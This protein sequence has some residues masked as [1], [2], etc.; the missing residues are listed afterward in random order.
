MKEHR[1]SFIS[2]AIDA[3]TERWSSGLSQDEHHIIQALYASSQAYVWENEQSLERIWTRVVQRR[4]YPALLQETQHE[5][6]EDE[7]LVSKGKAIREHISRGTRFLPSHSWPATCP[8]TLR[9]VLGIGTAVAVV[10]LIIVSWVLLFSGLRQSTAHH[11]P[12]TQAGALQQDVHAG[13]LVCSFSANA[14][15]YPVPIQPTLDWSAGG[16]I[17]VT[18]QNLKTVSARGC[19]TK[20][21]NVLPQAQQAT[22]SPDGKRLL[23]LLAGKAEVLDASTGHIIASFQG[24]APGSFV[25]QSV[26]VS[27]GTIVSAVQAPGTKATSGT[28]GA[29][30]IQIWNA[31]TGAFIRTVLTFNSGEQFLGLNVGMFPISPSGKYVAVQKAHSDVAIWN[32]ASGT[33]VN[34]IPYHQSAGL[35][36][37]RGFSCAGLA[38]CC[39]S[40]D[41][42]GSDRSALRVLHG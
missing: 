25:A 7:R 29:L 10:F 22:W 28:P 1:D 32:I 30:F 2:E 35:V 3:Q 9:H 14:T 15:G 26:W 27:H 8:R 21:A 36:T 16:Q 13:T 34:S 40:A 41:L 4:G 18:Y 19:A 23:A 37:S 24:D 12:A 31:S 33:L 42:V 17:A 38:Q 11:R 20:S 6:P 5:Q 39:R